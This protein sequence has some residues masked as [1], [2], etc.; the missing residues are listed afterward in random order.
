MSIWLLQ[1]DQNGSCCACS[2]R[3][4]PCDLCDNCGPNDVV[5]GGTIPFNTSIVSSNPTGYIYKVGAYAGSAQFTNNNSKVTVTSSSTDYYEFGVFSGTIPITILS[6]FIINLLIKSGDII[7]MY[8]ETMAPS[9]FTYTNQINNPTGLFGGCDPASFGNCIPINP[10]SLIY[11]D[12]HTNSFLLGEAILAFQNGTGSSPNV[13]YNNVTFAGSPFVGPGVG[14]G[15]PNGAGN[16]QSGRSSTNIGGSAGVLAG[17]P[18]NYNGTLIVAGLNPPYYDVFPGAV[19]PPNVSAIGPILHG[20]TVC[21]GGS[22]LG[23]IVD[24]AQIALSMES[25]SA[26]ENST[27]AI[28]NVLGNTSSICP[29]SITPM[30]QSV[31]FQI[32]NISNISFADGSSTPSSFVCAQVQLINNGYLQILDLNKNPVDLTT[33]ISKLVIVQN[34]L[35]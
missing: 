34:G 30:N 26:N 15:Q 25:S 12:S 35:P 27:F 4:N 7:T 32:Q 24:P 19:L 20:G 21:N 9:V 5:L 18:Y 29:L 28:S 22:I 13:S 2:V 23:I 31:N 1:P 3:Q 11:S 33:R 6:Q 16:N 10:I 17:T 8:G 14:P